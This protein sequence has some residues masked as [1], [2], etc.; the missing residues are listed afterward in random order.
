VV[1]ENDKQIENQKE[2]RER[3]NENENENQNQ[4]QNQNEN[5]KRDQKEEE[6]GATSDD[7]NARVTNDQKENE[8]ANET[9][10]ESEG[11]EMDKPIENDE[12]RDRVKM[13]ND[14]IEGKEKDA[15]DAGKPVQGEEDK[16]E[17]K[18]EGAEEEENEES[19]DFSET[20]QKTIEI[21]DEIFN[22]INPMQLAAFY[23]LM[24]DT[25]N[26]GY[27]AKKNEMDK[28]K[29]ALIEALYKK[30][31]AL[32]ALEELDP[33]SDQKS[34][35][36]ILFKK[37]RTK[38]KSKHLEKPMN[39][40]ESLDSLEN[41]TEVIRKQKKPLWKEIDENF[42]LLAQWCDVTAEPKMAIL[43]LKREFSKK[44]FSS[45]L[46]L[47]NKVISSGVSGLTSLGNNQLN[48]ILFWEIQSPENPGSGT[49]LQ[50]KFE[51]Y[52]E[53][54]YLNLGWNQVVQNEI[55]LNWIRAPP[56]FQP[57]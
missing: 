57:L 14:S 30:I 40:S 7:Q 48:R 26:D 4:N 8:D 22:L 11:G 33:D 18:V 5:E 47:I 49:T 53:L 51:K 17:D 56:D 41:E 15:E 10:R 28:H 16:V 3:D 38:S 39:S 31:Q 50:E 29:E 34:E 42:E 37:K 46:K 12:A 36:I 24:H 13:A 43:K 1:I 25:N 55:K 27:K 52:R 20:L 2:E 54:I 21:C 35:T 19:V 6:N 9:L 44:K 45:C 32:M 23:G